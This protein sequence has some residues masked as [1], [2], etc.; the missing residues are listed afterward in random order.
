[1]N[2][3]LKPCPFCGRPASIHG[4]WGLE[5]LSCSDQIGDC[6]GAVVGMPCHT[7]QRR[8]ASIS[9]W[10]TRA[11]DAQPEPA[12]PTVVEPI[13]MV[14][15]CPACGLQHVDAPEAVHEPQPDGSAHAE[16]HWNN[17]P[18]RSHKC[19]ICG[20]IWRPAD[21]ATNG[22]QAVKTK[23]KDDS[24]IAATPPRAALTDEQIE[25]LCGLDTDRRVR[26]YEHDFY[27]LVS[28]GL[29]AR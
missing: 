9:A 5:V 1:M 26:F 25:R 10:N 20:H 18:H 21:V 29:L 12:A 13:D 3:E 24:P 28:R 6:P 22:V 23:G 19:G 15:H 8:A 2:E 4:D 14:L 16:E 11:P 7:P 27:E 17:P